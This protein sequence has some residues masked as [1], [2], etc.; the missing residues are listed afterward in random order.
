M[1]SL[2]CRVKCGLLVER[3]G[4]TYL[5]GLRIWSE[6]LHSLEEGLYEH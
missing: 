2:E 5:K 4:K 3:L 1:V 6:R